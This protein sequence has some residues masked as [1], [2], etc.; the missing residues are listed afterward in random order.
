M[1]GSRGDF[2]GDITDINPELEE[3]LEHDRQPALDLGSG[4]VGNIQIHAT[5]F[6]TFSLQN[7]CRNRPCDHV[8][9]GEFHAFG[10]IP[11][12]EPLTLHIFQET[13]LP[14][15]CLGDESSPCIIGIDRSCRMELY[16]LHVDQLGTCVVPNGVPIAGPAGRVGGNVIYPGSSSCGEYGGVCQHDPERSLPVQAECSIHSPPLLQEGN[17]GDFVLN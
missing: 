6:R 9:C 8:S 13:P 11:F 14:A 16:L 1:V 17:D 3:L 7:L 15:N 5:I 2:H 12:H 10:I 4:E